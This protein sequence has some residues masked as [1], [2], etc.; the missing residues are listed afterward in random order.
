MRIR[1]WIAAAAAA[2]AVIS[3]GAQGQTKSG[4]GGM[5]ASSYKN[6]NVSSIPESKIKEYAQKAE[7]SGMGLSD[8]IALAQS[9]G[10]STMQLSQLKIRLSRYLKDE[11]SAS[12][13]GTGLEAGAQTATLSTREL[14]EDRPQLADT[15]V[16][17]YSMFNRS[18]LTFEP[19]QSLAIGDAYTIGAGDQIAIDIYGATDQ[20]YELMVGT[21]G[22]IVVPM[23]GPIRVG[24]M[25]V[26]DARNTVV[27]KLRRIHSD[28]GGGS[29]ANLRVTSAS[30][31]TV[32]VMGEAHN[33]GT[34]TVSSAST[35]FNV[36]YLSG[37][38][39]IDGSYRDIQLIRGG[40]IIAHLDVYDFLLNG[41]NDVNPSLANGDIVMIPTY[42]KRIEVKGEFKRNGLFE[43]KEGET[44]ADII[45]YAGGFTPAAQSD[46]IGVYRIGKYTTEYKDVT[47]PGA[48][49]LCNGDKIECGAKNT[50]R[51]DNTVKIEGAVF[52]PGIFEYSEGLTLK[53]L[54]EK[55]G[56][57]TENA[58]LSRG[59]ITRYK[60]DYTLESVNFNVLD[61][62]NGS[63]DVSIKANDVVTIASIDDMREKPEVAI[64]GNVANEGKYDYRENLTLGDLIVLAGGMKEYTALPNVEI[65]RRVDSKDL[66]DSSKDTRTM[67]TVS[68]TPDLSLDGEGNNFKLEPFDAVYIRQYAAAA[69]DISVYV[70][71]EVWTPGLYA[72][73]KAGT[74]V[75]ELM[76]RCGGF[77]VNADRS[78]ARLYRRLTMSDEEREIRLRLSAL[79]GDTA[80]YYLK[81]KVEQYEFVSFDLEKALSNPNSDDDLILCDGDRIEIPQKSQTVRV[82][83]IVQN[84]M[85]MKWVDGM[86]AD[87]YIDAV[88]GFAA[89]AFKR[90]TYVVNPNGESKRVRHFLFVRR[91]PE[92]KPGSE[93][94]VPARPERNISTLTTFVGLGSTLVSIAIAVVALT[95]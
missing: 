77:S 44:V 35:L 46:H 48:E 79:K 82:T 72:L 36:L 60:E 63:A 39:S 3:T 29:K 40:R 20:T 70:D 58:F 93:I 78:G 65:V 71:G 4:L 45:R 18:G 42:A 66:D 81:N 91:Y 31:V 68:I 37:G 62:S 90:K 27:A 43:A 69:K 11:K 85:N 38:P 74:R 84:P 67:E 12:T 2:L 49:L 57:L 32:S 14:P 53:E 56:G 88:G 16:F 59:V 23:V 8:V 10:A 92:V 19:T 22:T 21:D 15:A 51:V 54:I 75:S 6:I 7:A 33:P 13:A 50:D 87:D 17:G 30:P 95:K 64:Y 25:T 89:N 94:V 28:L 9:K 24:G 52:A 41:K 86:R 26:A 61:A 1:T 73:S 47:D 5:S 34:F 83:G 80:T 76:S 55:A